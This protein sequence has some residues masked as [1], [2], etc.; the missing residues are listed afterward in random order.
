MFGRAACRIRHCVA[1]TGPTPPSSLPLRALWS[2]LSTLYT[3]P[4]RHKSCGIVGLANVGKSTLFNALTQTQLAQA[5][6]FPFCTIEP[7]ITSVAVKDPLLHSLA[8]LAH[9]RRTVYTQLTLVDIAGLIRGASKGAG[10]GAKF[11]ANIRDVDVVLH[12][13]RC[14]DDDEVIHIHQKVDPVDDMQ[15]VEEELMLADMATVDKRIE[16]AKKKVSHPTAAKLC[17]L[18]A[19]SCPV[20]RSPSVSVDAVCSRLK[21]LLRTVSCVK[22][23]SIASTPR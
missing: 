22:V 14:F 4:R 9:S 20:R 8:Q 5:A 18:L 23:C 3:L 10:M 21:R 7:N 16:N 13:V 6:N 17:C 12:V 15:C 2:N 1:S 11:L 19:T